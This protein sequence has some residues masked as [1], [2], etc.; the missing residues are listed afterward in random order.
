MTNNIVSILKQAQDQLIESN[1]Y[2][3][4]L[5]DDPQ[6][7]SKLDANILLC[8]VLCKPQ[9][10]LIANPEQI[11][12]LGQTAMYFALI[13]RRCAGEPIAYITGQK[14]FFSLI[15]NVSRDTLIP[16]PETEILV[17]TVLDKFKDKSS[18]QISI[19]DLGTGSGA[20]AIALAK[21]RPKWK[22]VAV[23]Q[24]IKAIEIAKKNANLNDVK[25]IEFIVSDWFSNLK[26]EHQFDC[27]V[28]NPPYIAS[29]DPYLKLGGVVHEPKSAL[30]AEHNGLGDIQ[31]II[32]NYSV[33]VNQNGF[34][35]FEHGYNQLESIKL[36]I[37]DCLPEKAQNFSSIL[38]YAGL[39]RVLMVSDTINRS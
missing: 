11:L 26:A 4:E 7:D 21:S 36:I 2:L 15:F 37:N 19:L 23:D 22:I 27:I 5:N 30:I 10:Y 9:A 8:H 20:I 28:S 25:N 14:E 6:I 17:E 3:P 39:P 38:D 35:I 12:P 32:Q 34:L 29:D 24:S 18:E 16:R 1:I 31:K 13:S 33:Y